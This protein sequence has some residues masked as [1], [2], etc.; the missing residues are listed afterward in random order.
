MH[1]D[2]LITIITIVR[3]DEKNIEETIKSVINQRDPFIEYIIGYLHLY[4]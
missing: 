4:Y 3:N 1:K 2:L